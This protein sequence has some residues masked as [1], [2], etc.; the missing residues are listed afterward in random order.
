MRRLG[1]VLTGVLV[2]AALLLWFAGLSL[3][4]W[5]DD[6]SDLVVLGYVLMISAIGLT[7]TIPERPHK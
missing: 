5:A 4:R 3:S 7:F 2:S 1:V 6:G